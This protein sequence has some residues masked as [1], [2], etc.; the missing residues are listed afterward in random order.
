MNTPRRRTR[1][2]HTSDVHLGTSHLAREELAFERFVDLAVAEQVDAVIIAGDLFD[3]SRVNDDLMEWTAAQLD[4]LPCPA[5]LH[6][7]N[8]DQLDDH[9]VYHR[10]KPEVRCRDVVFIDDFDGQVIEVPGTDVTVWGRAMFEHEPSFR[11]VAAVPERPGDRWAIIVAHGLMMD[12]ENPT[13]RSSPIYPSDFHGLDWDYVALGH[14]HAHRI[15]RLGSMTACYPG[16]TAYSVKGEPGA[17]LVDLQ[18][19]RHVELTW[20]PLATPAVEAPI[21]PPVP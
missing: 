16:A 9:S 2:L 17:V 14:V 4:R 11:P 18:E 1:L 19:G 5:V 12:D 7:G 10:F 20:R 8:H 15:Y 6:T 3:H 13:Y 21:S